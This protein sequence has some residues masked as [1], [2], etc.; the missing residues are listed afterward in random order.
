MTLVSGTGGKNSFLNSQR[1]HVRW[2]QKREESSGYADA[3][4][5]F[6]HQLGRIFTY[7]LFLEQGYALLRSGGRLGVIVPSGIYS[8]AW[9]QPLRE[10]FLD[11]CR[12][13]WLFGFEN[14][15]GI[16]EIHRSFKFNPII[17]QKGGHTASIRTAFMRR[18][19]ADWEQAERFVTEYPRER[20]VQFSPKSKVLLEI[21]SARD[22]ELLTTHL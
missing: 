14:R 2:K 8:D 20:V 21:P 18:S 10:L 16:F 3:D 11:H 7:K 22:L 19:L 17:V 4:H 6:R 13:E 9:S 12:W 1:R 15:E 5:S